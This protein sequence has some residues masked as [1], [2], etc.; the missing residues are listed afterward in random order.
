MQ[1]HAG[2]E[3]NLYMLNEKKEMSKQQVN[4]RYKRS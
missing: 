4:I 3:C 1:R 2:H